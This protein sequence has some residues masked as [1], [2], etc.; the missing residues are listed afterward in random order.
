MDH[1]NHM[2]YNPKRLVRLVVTRPMFFKGEPLAVGQ[3]FEIEARQ[4]GEVLATLRADFVD[5]A[6]RPLVYRKVLMWS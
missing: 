1:L 3:D 2:P 5:Q 6:D 4:A